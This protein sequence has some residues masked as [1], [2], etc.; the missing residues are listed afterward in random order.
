MMMAATWPDPGSAVAV[1]DVPFRLVHFKLPFNKPNISS[2][3]PST[4][5]VP[6]I[7]F[8]YQGRR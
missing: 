8:G 5:I 1:P 2:H 7:P 3:N 4:W 6:C